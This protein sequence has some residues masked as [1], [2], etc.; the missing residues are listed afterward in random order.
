MPAIQAL[1][2]IALLASYQ[3][4]IEWS[5]EVYTLAR[6]YPFIGNSQWFKDMAGKLLDA[7]ATQLPKEVEKA[8]SS[9]GKSLDLWQVIEE[10]QS[11]KL[12]RPIATQSLSHRV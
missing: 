2:A 12:N 6:T 11:N 3:G 8:V 9:R 7:A 1:P 4:D 10:W 5:V